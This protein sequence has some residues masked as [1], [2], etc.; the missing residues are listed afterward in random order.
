MKQI[1]AKQYNFKSQDDLVDLKIAGR[2]VYKPDTVNVYDK[3][4]RM[5]RSQVANDSDWVQETVGLTTKEYY[6]EAI[7]KYLNQVKKEC[8]IYKMINDSL[9][10]RRIT[11]AYDVSITEYGFLAQ[12]VKEVFPNLVKK[13]TSTG[14][15]AVN[16]TS[17]IP[18]I[19]QAVK[20]LQAENDQLKAYL[21]LGNE[22]KKSN[23]AALVS[24]LKSK[25]ASVSVMDSSNNLASIS[26]NRPNP[27]SENT[28][29]DYFLPK[30]VVSAYI[31]I[32]DLNGRQLRSLS[33]TDRGSS[34]VTINGGDLYA[35]LFNY[36][37]VVDGTLIDSKRMILTD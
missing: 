37:L 7:T 25:S 29:I 18:I 30:S 9:G 20:E 32:Y 22:A 12:E 36:A 15:Y 13:D 3:A 24:N 14:L 27:F 1:D 4:Y 5:M 16:Y 21:G 35:G 8:S 19:F 23:R 17:F 34:S 26:Q 10:L 11:P 28:V 31:Y 2:Y 6:Q 33:L